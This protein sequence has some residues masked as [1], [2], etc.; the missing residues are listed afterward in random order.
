MKGIVLIG[1]MGA[2]KTTI[3]RML[4]EEINVG[5][6]DFDDVIIEEIGMTIQE[7]FDQF[8]EEAFR[9]RET[10]ILGRY[11]DPQ[12]VISTGGGIVLKEENRKLLKQMPTVV[13]LKTDADEL[14][15]RLKADHT[16]IR[17]LVVSKS[18][19]EIKEVYLPRI[20]FYEESASLIVETTGKSPAEI[21]A[22]ILAA[23]VKQAG[24]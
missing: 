22:E 20:P 18:P 11:L 2:G 1:F 8:G 17:P 13:Y 4:S 9:K 14:V 15:K 12:H 6:L 23:D 19:E 3:G 10:E 5:H 21:V 7:Y 24:A 16:S